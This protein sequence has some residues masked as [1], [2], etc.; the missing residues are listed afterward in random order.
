MMKDGEIVEDGE[1]EQ[2]FTNPRHP[3][4]ASLIKAAPTLPDVKALTD[5]SS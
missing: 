5:V 4:T 3:Y 1:T 2:V